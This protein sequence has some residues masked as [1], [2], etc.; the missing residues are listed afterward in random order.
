MKNRG[1]KINSRLKFTEEEMKNAVLR[2]VEDGAPLNTVSQE[3]GLCKKTLKSYLDKYLSTAAEKK[4]E[5]TF[6][7]NYEINQVFTHELEKVFEQSLL[8]VDK[9]V[10]RINRTY[11]R[12]AAFEFA[13]ICNVHVPKT[14]NVRKQA[15]LD[16]MYGFLNRHPLIKRTVIT[17]K[18]QK[19]GKPQIQFVDVAYNNY[20]EETEEEVIILEDADI[21]NVDLVTVNTES[22]SASGSTVSRSVASASAAGAAKSNPTVFQRSQ[23]STKSD[24]LNDFAEVFESAASGSSAKSKESQ[25]NWFDVEQTLCVKTAIDEFGDNLREAYC[26]IAHD[27]YVP[28]DRVFNLDEIALVVENADAEKVVVTACCCVSANGYAL[29]PFMIFPCHK[30]RRQLLKGYASGVCGIASSEGVVDD[31]LFLLVL[32]HFRDLVRTTPQYKAVLIVDDDECHVTINSIDFCER[33]GIEL[34]TLPPQSAGRLQPIERYTYKMLKSYFNSACAKFRATNADYAVSVYDV[35]ALFNSIYP[36]AFTE[37]N[38]I[39]GF[40][41]TGLYPLDERVF[42][43]VDALPKKLVK[44]DLPPGSLNQ[45][46]ELVPTDICSTDGSDVSEGESTG[47]S[48]TASDDEECVYS[49]LVTEYERELA[50]N[51]EK[52]PMKEYFNGLVFALCELESYGGISADR[53]FNM[54]EIELVVR[55][56]ELEKSGL[57]LV[58][59]CC[60]NAAGESVPPMFVY[61]NADGPLDS[62]IEGARCYTIDQFEHE[63]DVFVAMLQHFAEHVKPTPQNRVLLVIDDEHSHV[64]VKS[65]DFCF[66]H[67]ILLVT[68]PSQAT[69]P[70]QPLEKTLFSRLTLNFSAECD[71]FLEENDGRRITMGDM[72][73]IFKNVYKKVFD[74]DVVVS[75]FYETGIWPLNENT[76]NAIASS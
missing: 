13:L 63:N 56:S 8:N 66:E 54:D 37:E 48:V 11:I 65:I 69:V 17:N 46:I 59:C 55:M 61:P 36:L 23:C 12:K 28:S 29:P 15:G 22:A 74:R 19:S 43:E 21:A 14:W 33:W 30:F 68:V 31:H 2:I 7:P 9:S 64:T 4:G 52:T 58:S 60:V 57:R 35:S 18:K 45:N 3:G 51:F 26:A 34:V 47:E 24:D 53:V 76:I 49:S 71:H 5:F 27:G 25:N 62:G 67:G 39:R 20:V 6:R 72:L 38:I 32:Q 10:E 40:N 70:L 50:E 44:D 41:E 16:W 1:E 75:S 73:V 42:A